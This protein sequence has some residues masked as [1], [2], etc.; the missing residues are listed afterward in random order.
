M[1]RV[2]D[3]AINYKL[4][5]N[6]ISSIDRF[7]KNILP[8]KPIIDPP[9]PGNYETID[10]E[11]SRL[12]RQPNILISPIPTNKSVLEKIELPGPG[13]YKPLVEYNSKVSHHYWLGDPTS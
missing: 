3:Q 10:L 11:K 1:D 9:G 6:D 12:L 7:G 13:A 8:R 2:R 4:S 5:G